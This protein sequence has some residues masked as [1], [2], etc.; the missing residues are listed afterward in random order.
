MNGIKVEHLTKIFEDFVAVDDVSFE[1][2]EGELVALLGPSGSGKSTILRIVAGL[3]TQGRGHVYLTGQNVTSLDPR[4]RKVGFVFQHYA[5]FKHMTVEKNIAFGLEVQKKNKTIIKEKIAELI[6]L[7]K[8]NGHEKHF[9]HQLSGG[10]RQRVALA[11][12]LAPEP[13]VLLLDEPFGSLDAKVRKTLAR[14]IRQLHDRIKVT[15]IFVTH[16]Q[17]EAME[18]SDKIIVVNR[19]RIEQIGKASEVYEHPKSKFVASFVG[20]VNV[21][22]GRTQDNQ[23]ALEGTEGRIDQKTK[24]IPNNQDIVFLVRPEEV[25]IKRTAS[26]STSILAVVEGIHYRGSFYEVDLRIG[27]N[28]IKSIIQKEKYK[29][30]PL[31]VGECV[32]VLFTQ[33]KVFEASEGPQAI[34]KMLKQ[35]G[36]IE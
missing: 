24:D 15:S 6:D 8:L 7:V 17:N 25:D 1:V 12:A 18:I 34:H 31:T 27:D 33:F 22:N 10:Q 9:P 4:K 26:K 28:E 11:R 35:L 19:G 14:W 36:Y 30:N 29:M 23:I 2:K 13:K 32:F 5:L 16:D 20:N 21:I 3:E